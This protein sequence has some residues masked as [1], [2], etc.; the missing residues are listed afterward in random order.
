MHEVAGPGDHDPLVPQRRQRPGQIVVLTRRQ[1]AVQRQ[2]HHRHVGFRP[3]VAQHRPGSVIQA[4]L[5]GLD[6]AGQRRHPGRQLG[7][8]GRRILHLVKFTREVAEI[9][10]GFRP[11]LGRDAQPV[12]LPVGG[13][14]HNA[15]GL[16]DGLAQ[17]AP[18]G[19]IGTAQRIH[20]R[21][22]AEEDG[23]LAHGFS[24]AASWPVRRCA[25][26]GS[27]RRPGRCRWADASRRRR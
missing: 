8:S 27:A 14:H 13:D 12:R 20:G 5:L 15:P 3:D 1:V 17:V 25:C 21:T 24:R 11:V 9:V 23:G 16:A 6:R 26:P 10:D 4:P 22:V 7:R 18:G 19:P 2:L